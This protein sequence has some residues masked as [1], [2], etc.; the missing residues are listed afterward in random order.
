MEPLDMKTELDRLKKRV[1]A[2]ERNSQ[3]FSIAFWNEE[4]LI[5]GTCSSKFF[6]LLSGKDFYYAVREI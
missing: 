5:N 2:L 6:A 3:R 1:R 4:E